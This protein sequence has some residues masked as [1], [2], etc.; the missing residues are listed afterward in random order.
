M[1][2]DVFHE[3]PAVALS[4]TLFVRGYVLQFIDAVAF[5]CHHADTLE[6]AVIE[7]K[8]IPAVQIGI[9]HGF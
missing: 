4:L 2:E 5:A 9:D 3:P 7:G 8:H 6:T 1:F